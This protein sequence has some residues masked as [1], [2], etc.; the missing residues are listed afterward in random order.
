MN[1]CERIVL[2]ITLLSL[3]TLQTGCV[4]LPNWIQ[5]SSNDWPRNP[6]DP[7]R[8]A[9]CSEIEVAI[10]NS[11]GSILY[12]VLDGAGVVHGF[13]LREDEI[14]KASL[15]RIR[16]HVGQI[17]AD[18]LQR[19]LP[20][21]KVSYRA[22]RQDF[23]EPRFDSPGYDPDRSAVCLLSYT[24]LIHCPVWDKRSKIGVSKLAVIESSPPLLLPRGQAYVPGMGWARDRA[25]WVASWGGG[26]G[27]RATNI[28]E[29]PLDCT[30]EIEASMWKLSFRP[31][32]VR[33]NYAALESATLKW[34]DR[35]ASDVAEQLNEALRLN[36]RGR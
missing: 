33:L 13:V 25:R 24:Y 14:D 32:T 34:A 8:L 22:R 35:R 16:D 17:F 2:A 31:Q 15:V 27:Q 12:G 19:A 3:A 7:A 11:S 18:H 29:Y 36:A 1:S 10:A 5:V 20:G 21:K 23:S 6:P 26:A 4:T 28:S 30:A 9:R